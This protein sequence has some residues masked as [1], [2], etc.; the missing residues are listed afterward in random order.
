MHNVPFTKWPNPVADDCEDYIDPLKQM[1][2]SDC[3]NVKPPAGPAGENLFSGSSNYGLGD[4]VSMWYAEVKNCK[5]FPGCEQSKGGATGH[6]TAMIW[7][8]D[9]LLTIGCHSTGTTLED[10][11]TRQETRRMT[12]LPCWECC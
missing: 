7:E 1:K 8:A 3:Y 6:F 10:A 9:G 11:G 12:T 2:H 4:A 5:K